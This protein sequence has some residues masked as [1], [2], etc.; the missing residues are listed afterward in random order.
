MTTDYTV[1][2]RAV[3]LDILL[4]VLEKGAFGH[5]VLRQAL[6]KYGYLEKSERAFLS[7]LAQ[8]CIALD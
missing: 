3:A 6:N 1:N 7:R 5:L 2:L 8:G 4:E